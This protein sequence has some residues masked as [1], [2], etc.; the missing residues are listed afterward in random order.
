MPLSAAEQKAAAEQRAAKEKLSKMNAAAAA[1]AA[2]AATA[3]TGTGTANKAPA[4]AQVTPTKEQKGRYFVFEMVDGSC[5]S[6]D[7]IRAADDYKQS[8]PTH[9]VTTHQWK[10]RRSRTNYLNKRESNPPKRQKKETPPSAEARIF[11]SDREKADK[12]IAMVKKENIDKANRIEGY[13]K[14][15][16]NSTLFVLVFRLMT[17]YNDDYW[18]WKPDWMVN[19]LCKFQYDTDIE[20]LYLKE[21]L[22]SLSHAYAS[23]PKGIDSTQTWTKKYTDKNNK[24]RTYDIIHAFGYITID[25]GTL[26][27]KAEEVVWIDKIARQVLSGV[28][29]ILKSKAWEWACLEAPGKQNFASV[30][31]NVDGKANFQKF[32]ESCIITIKPVDHLHKLLVHQ[33]T[34]RIIDHLYQHRLAQPKYAPEGDV[35]DDDQEDAAAAEGDGSA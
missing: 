3:G 10:Q 8:Y 22:S 9:I 6:V 7:G 5:Q 25:T 16:S 21:F 32:I 2:N 18:G 4:P 20:N 14:T 17:Q 19:L 15:T 33:E 24:E 11:S 35:S 27:S 34:T 31:F 30:I 28:H 23:D 26:S 1:A 12:I 13:T 29:E